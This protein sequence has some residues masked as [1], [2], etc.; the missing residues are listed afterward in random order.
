M[1]RL[2]PASH[3]RRR[4]LQM[5]VAAIIFSVAASVPLQASKKSATKKYALLVG[6]TEYQHCKGISPLVGPG[7]DVPHFAAVLESLGFARE[8]ITQLVGWPSDAKARPSYT[9]IVASF[10]D[11]VKKASAN[12][13]IVILLAGHGVEV[14]IPSGR[15]DRFDPRN[16]KLTGMDRIFLPADVKEW[17]EG[18]LDNALLDDQIG[19]WLDAMAAKNAAVW[20]IL[21]CCHSGT[22]ARDMDANDMERMRE[23]RPRDLKIPDQAI[24]DAA[25]R[26]KMALKKLGERDERFRSF[27]TPGMLSLSQ[28]QSDKGSVVAFYA[29]LPYEKAPELPRPS[30]AARVSKNY[31]GLLSYTVAGILKSQSKTRMTYR[32]LEQM[33]VASYQAERGSRAPTPFAEGGLDREVL[34]MAVW[35]KRAEMILEHTEDSLRVSGGG[36]FNLTPGSVLAVHPPANDP[37]DFKEILGYVK[38]LSLTPFQA[39]VAVCAFQKM[40][41]VQP[42]TL[43]ALARCKLVSQDLGDMRLK[44]AIGKPV[45]TDVKPDAVNIKRRQNLSEALEL[46]PSE[47]KKL[48][49]VTEDQA[50]ADWVL[51]LAEDKVQL[52]PGDGRCTIDPAEDIVGQKTAGHE[53]SLSR[54]I[55]GKYDA[56]DA[57]AIAEGLELDLQKLFTW[58]NL[59]RIAA[60]AGSKQDEGEPAL[61]FEVFKMKDKT[62][63]EGKLEPGSLLR[64]GQRIE[65][66]LSNQSNEDLWITVIFLDANGGIKLA[67]PTETIQARKAFTRPIRGTISGSSYGKEGFV[68]LAVP[69]TVHKNR[70]DFSFLEQSP[71]AKEEVRSRGERH[72]SGEDLAQTPFEHLLTAAAFGTGK[73]RSFEPDVVTNPVIVS[74][75]WM[76]VPGPASVIAP[77]NP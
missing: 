13:Q 4:L 42:A 8:N 5:L 37:R 11:L 64:P 77:K 47:T 41:A 50:K 1:R 30:S 53:R 59:W 18:K 44:L 38:V 23:V 10:E 14:P 72:R 54:I 29:C 52:R 19:R 70:P 31:F 48:L 51:W 24:E 7:N 63:V 16:P 15:E 28:R 40:P 2:L 32:E 55:F 74:L 45:K 67:A 21:D 36:V 17:N 34:G 49:M 35:P 76:T 3:S 12:A 65:A 20:I 69:V 68:V 75:S 61:R 27:E 25:A 57:S 6:C 71:L 22:M 66:R 58:C 46:L 60:S 33:L 43:P 62:N 39:E 73:T 56:D 9:N 26:A